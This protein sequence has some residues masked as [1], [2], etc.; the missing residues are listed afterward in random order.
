M[1]YAF[2]ENHTHIQNGNY[3]YDY[4]FFLFYLILSKCTCA[5]YLLRSILGSR[6][7]MDS[8]PLRESE[9]THLQEYNMLRKV[10]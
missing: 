10:V 9:S 6:E 2:T 1:F 7:P 4:L 5:F 8:M 3:L